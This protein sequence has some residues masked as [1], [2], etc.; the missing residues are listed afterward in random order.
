MKKRRR[1]APKFTQGIYTIEQGM[2]DTGCPRDVVFSLFKAIEKEG[3]A[4]CK[5]GRNGHQTRLQR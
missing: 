5:I 1:I 2:A 4:I 3:I